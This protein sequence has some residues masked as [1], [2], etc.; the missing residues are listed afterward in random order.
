MANPVKRRR[1]DL[2]ITTATPSLKDK[3]QWPALLSAFG[4][5]YVSIWMAECDCGRNSTM[6]GNAFFFSTFASSLP[7]NVE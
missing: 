7:P 4:T 1:I 5:K 3:K 6:E 2:A